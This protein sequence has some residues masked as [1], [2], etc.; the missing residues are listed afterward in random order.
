MVMCDG[1]GGHTLGFS[2]CSSFHARLFHFNSLNEVDPTIDG[3]FAQTLQ[4]VCPERNKNQSAGAFLDSTS[5]NF[6]NRYY[7]EILQGK[8]IFSSDQSLFSDPET[9]ALVN[10]YAN[11][12]HAFF[13][14]FV[15]SMTRMGNIAL[16]T[17][18]DG[19][20]RKRCHFVNS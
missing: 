18:Q 12:E 3:T 8:G 4:T 9:H 7:V 6:D 14:N 15:I 20:I 19:E 10:F 2:H 5:T 16:K 11:D 13:A 17:D 1:K